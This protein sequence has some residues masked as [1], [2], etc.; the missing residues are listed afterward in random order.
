MSRRTF[1]R[2]FKLRI[3]RSISSGSVSKSK[4]CRDEGLSETTLSKWLVQYETLGEESFKGD[5]WRASSAQSSEA[6][7]RE[8][9]SAVGRLHMENELLRQALSKKPSSPGSGAK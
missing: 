3:C 9:E 7:I 2:D 1:D 5:A 4:A 8:L 6:R